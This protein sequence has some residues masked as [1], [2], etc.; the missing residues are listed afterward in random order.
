[1]VKRKVSVCTASKTAAGA[2]EGDRP[3]TSLECREA[4]LVSFG[5]VVVGM[6]SDEPRWVYVIDH[7]RQRFAVNARPVLDDRS[8][9]A[10]VRAAASAGDRK[11]SAGSIS[12]T[13]A[14]TR[15]DAV[16]RIKRRAPDAVQF[17]TRG[18]FAVKG[19]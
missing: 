18:I 5:K 17:D 7:D 1:M 14:P 2:G 10:K 6:G 12:V 8:W 3:A 19:A 11:L 15:A 16:A 4:L 13:K 9:R